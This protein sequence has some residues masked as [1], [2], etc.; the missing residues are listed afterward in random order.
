MSVFSQ[1]TEWFHAF[2]TLFY[3]HLCAGCGS[4]N[5]ARDEAICH[6]CIAHFPV[7]GFENQ[8]NNPI[9]KLFWGRIPVTAASS[10]YYFTRSSTI[11]NAL[12][13][14]KYKSNINAGMVMGRLLGYS[15]KQSDRFRNIDL[16]VPLPLYPKKEKNR[17]YNQAKII[18]A[19]MQEVMNIPVITDAITR[20]RYT[21][22]QTNKNRIDRWKNVGDVFSLQKPA[23][24]KGKNILLTD[25]VITTGASLEAC[26]ATLCKAEIG[27]LY[28]ATLAFSDQ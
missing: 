12:H 19:G 9:E 10:Q 14:L 11:Q 3:P 18:A 28:I 8:Q 22:S 26:G 6:H 5:I 25:D 7:T 2:C 4:N 24:L 1:T 20:I 23:L 17:G 13:A 21:D 15:L 27:K 16:I